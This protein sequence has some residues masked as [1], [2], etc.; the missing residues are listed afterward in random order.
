MADDETMP[1]NVLKSNRF[2]INNGF[3]ADMFRD[4]LPRL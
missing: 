3:N 1:A 2:T 4:D